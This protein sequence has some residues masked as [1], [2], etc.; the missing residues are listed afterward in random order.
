MRLVKPITSVA[1]RRL[2]SANS[3]LGKGTLPAVQN[4]ARSARIARVKAVRLPAAE[5]HLTDIDPPAC[6]EACGIGAMTWVDFD[7]PTPEA[8]KLI[9]AAKPMNAAAG[10]EPK[11]RYVGRHL[12]AAAMSPRV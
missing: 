6:V 11:I 2:P 3:S 7:A 5:V 12:D 10:T 1:K 4:T 8:E 9:A